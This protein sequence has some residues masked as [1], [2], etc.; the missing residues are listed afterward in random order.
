MLPIV[1]MKSVWPSGSARAA[2]SVPIV[3]LAPARFS[4]TTGWP[5]R[6]ARRGARSR[7]T[8][9]VP[10]PGGN[11]TMIRIGLLGKAWAA[12]S[13]RPKS[14][15][16]IFFIGS[17]HLDAGVARE[18][19]ERVGLGFHVGAELLGRAARHHL[20]AALEVFLLELVP[21]HDSTDFRI[22]THEDLARRARG[23]D[24]PVPRHVLEIGEALLVQRGNFRQHRR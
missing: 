21:R 24:D 16:M 2:A 1:A 13:A 17:F 8:M 7:A 11:A 20:D 12:P 19:R 6:S 4:T 23:R 10:P 3:P 9:S 18:L 14:S 22:E 15:A 5:Q